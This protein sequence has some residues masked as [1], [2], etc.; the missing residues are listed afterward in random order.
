MPSSTAGLRRPSSRSS[1]RPPSVPVY[2][3]L[4]DEWHPTQMLAD[5]LTMLERNDGR[6]ASELS[7]AFLGDARFNVGV[8]SL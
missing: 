2:N 3:G 8:R 7:F 1:L 5:L 4:T 6:P